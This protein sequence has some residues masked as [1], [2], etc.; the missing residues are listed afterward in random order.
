MKTKKQTSIVT[1][2]VIIIGVVMLLLAAVNALSLYLHNSNAVEKSISAFG[3]DLARN[4]AAQVDIG[5]YQRF[6]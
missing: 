2:I 1:N 3:M 5:T 6:L 4:A